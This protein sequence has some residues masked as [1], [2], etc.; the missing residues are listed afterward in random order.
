MKKILALLFF[1]MPS[2]ACAQVTCPSF[3]LGLVLTPGQWTA[4]FNAKQNALGYTPVN[5]AGDVMQG[6]LRFSGAPPTLTS[7]GTSPSV[8]GN[9]QVGEVTMGTGSPT[10]CVITFP[11]AYTSKPVCI[12]KWQ[13]GLTSTNYTVSTTAITLTQTATSSNLVDY[14]CTGLQ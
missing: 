13:T 1:L 6:L 11:V 4:C 9:G 10:G 5:K 2:I 8:I 7:C 12:V 3:Y 14:N